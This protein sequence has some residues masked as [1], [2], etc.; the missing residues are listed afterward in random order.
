[1][2]SYFNV[3]LL[4]DMYAYESSGAYFVFSWRNRTLAMR[5]GLL[6]ESVTVL[7]FP[8][9]VRYMHNLLVYL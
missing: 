9:T 4:D 8:F 7:T 3:V 1:L 6:N 2:L 5:I